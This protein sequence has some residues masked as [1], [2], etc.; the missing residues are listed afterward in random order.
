MS[1]GGILKRS[2][3]LALAL[4]V[5]LAAA[6][7]FTPGPSRFRSFD[8]EAVGQAEAELWRAYY[9]RRRVDLASGLML[10]ANRDFG[11]SPFDSIRAGLSAAEAARTFQRSRSRA[12]ARKRRFRR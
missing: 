11:L 7:L 5:A 9:E 10:N 1:A 4:L 8:P 6:W 3:T 2:I 12:G